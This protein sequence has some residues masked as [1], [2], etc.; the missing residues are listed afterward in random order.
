[1]TK[2]TLGKAAEALAR[3]GYYVFPLKPRGK[4]PIIKAWRTN[5]SNKIDTI[6]EWWGKHP[7][8]NIGID[9]GKS[10]KVVIDLDLK[11]GVNGPASWADLTQRLGLTVHTAISLTGGGGQHLFFDAGELAI[12]NSQ[13]K[14][15]PG[16]DVRGDGGYIV[17]PPSIHES[18]KA[19]KWDGTTTIEPLPSALAELLNRP[20]DTAE[21][22]DPWKCYTLADARRPRPEMKWYVRGI[23]AERSLTIW[24]GAPGCL[25]SMILADLAIAVAYGQKW[26]TPPPGVDGKG[27]EVVKTPVLWIDF[28]NGSRR[29][30]ERFQ[31]LA[32]TRKVPNSTPLYYYSMPTPGLDAGN[33]EHIAKLIARIQAVGAGLVI[34]DNL[35]LI[36]GGRVEN[37]SEM[38][39]VMAGL[40]S[41]TEIT[42]CAVIV[43]HHQRK[44]NGTLSRAGETLRGHGAIEAN[45]D[46]ALLV[47]REDLVV[48]VKPTKER[49][50]S[51]A[52]FAARFS[53]EQ[54]SDLELSSARF[55]PATIQDQQAEKIESIQAEILKALTD[56]ELSKSKLLDQCT[57][58][59]D[60]KQAALSGLCVSKQVVSKAG[61]RAGSEIYSLPK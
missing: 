30:H 50:P 5:S 57:G 18:G 9:V 58:R 37:D 17:A 20:D 31:A 13:S 25:K 12:G 10:H 40:R 47:T 46:A 24:F 27:I 56:G 22:A 11:D 60:M 39:S 28:D 16:I 61:Q 43:I 15:G 41:I 6:R 21:S 3:H 51:I 38:Q 4:T 36:S 29:T 48:T 53:F 23:V 8:A 52:S 14:L 42:G 1:M 55:W 59:Y 54:R 7:D 26:L 19:Y 35:L 33:G 44:A 34:I 2:Q 45:I 49:G 32:D